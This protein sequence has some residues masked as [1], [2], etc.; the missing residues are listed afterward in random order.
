MDVIEGMAEGQTITREELLEIAAYNN[1][2]AMIKE[3][4]L[5]DTG[6]ALYRKFYPRR[7]SA[8]RGGDRISP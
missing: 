6:R 7:R 5:R 1:Q 4:I 2:V 3:A 8:T